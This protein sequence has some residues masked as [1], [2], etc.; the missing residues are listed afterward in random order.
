MTELR[1]IMRQECDLWVAQC[2]DLDITMQGST[3]TECRERMSDQILV[4]AITSMESTGEL[5]GGIA[6]A[7]E[8]F[9]EIWEEAEGSAFCPTD[10]K[11]G[12]SNLNIGMRLA[13]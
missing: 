11:A 1:V 6:K 5:F 10:I 12:G 7:P 3:P 13:G 8:R 4:E 9:Q 2:V